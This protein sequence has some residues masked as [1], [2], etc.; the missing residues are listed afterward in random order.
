[1]VTDR[2]NI[3]LMVMDPFWN[4]IGLELEYPFA[5]PAVNVTMLLKGFH[6]TEFASPN[7]SPYR[8]AVREGLRMDSLGDYLAV[9]ERIIVSGKSNGAVCL[10]TTTAYERSLDFADVPRERAEKAF[11]RPRGHL[12]ASEI[13][14]FTDYMMWRIV[15]MSAK[16]D[17]P[18]QI[19]T[20]HAR[21]QGSNPMLL[22]DLIVANPKTRFILF[23]GGYP[24]VGET[25]AIATRHKNVWIDSV[26]LPTIKIGRAHV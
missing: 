25:G 12:S 21:I 6:P 24:W 7:D 1:M 13:K 5:V 11:G 16:H 26:W 3:E 23:H 19:H 2:A 18:F 17:I 20:G 8:F 22:M 4:R 9:V 10:K 14:D 15:E